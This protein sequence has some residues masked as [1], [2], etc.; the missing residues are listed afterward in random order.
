MT[1]HWIGVAAAD[2]IA[3]GQSGGFMQVNHG[4]KAPLLRISTG[5]TVAYYS[6]T[7]EYRGNDRLMAFTALGRVKPGLPYQGEMGSDFKPFRRDVEWY[8]TR[9]APITPLL[10]HLSFTRGQKNWGYK[11]RFGLFEISHEDMLVIA[12]AMGSY[13][14]DA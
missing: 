11:F 2:H 5:D 7:R 13:L 3:R 1:K 9:H 6:P 8:E 12:T 14:T 4:K 10:E